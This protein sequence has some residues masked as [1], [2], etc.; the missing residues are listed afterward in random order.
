MLR[1]SIAILGAAAIACRPPAPP[2]ADAVVAWSRLVATSTLREGIDAPVASRVQAYTSIALY[3]AHAA[4]ARSGLRTLAGQLNGLWHVPTP[5]DRGT[6]DGAI[7]AAEAARVVLDS[8]LTGASSATR[9][10]IDS[11]SRAQIAARVSVGVTRSIADRSRE[12]G[13]SIAREVLAWAAA[14]GFSATRNRPWRATDAYGKWTPPRAPGSGVVLAGAPAIDNSSVAPTIRV[15]IRARE[16]YWGRLRNFALRN[17]DECEAPR[18]PDFS[19][20]GRE[21]RDSLA[22]LSA[23]K[24]VVAAFWID[25]GR[26]TTALSRWTSIVDSVITRRNMDFGSATELYALSSIAM[27]DAYIAA[28][29]EKYRS[30]IARPQSAATQDSPEYPSADAALAGAT[31][32]VLARLLGDSIAFVHAGRT[33][34]NFSR[35]RDEAAFATMYAGTQFVPSVTGGL[36]QGQCVASRVL[37]RL[38]TRPR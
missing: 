2:T 33:F 1:R 26:T 30:L 23:D 37:G 7:V 32:S 18:A 13:A 15:S 19:A 9:T 35:A 28:W 11:A 31:A 21:L 25:S 17:A 27:A 4:D 24:R 34:P 5:D 22:A 12:H 38:K 14:D 16:P 8:M 29:K 3:E 6:L 20:M 10:A 36:A